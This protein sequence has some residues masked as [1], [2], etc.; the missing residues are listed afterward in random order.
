MNC[1]RCNSPAE[2]NEFGGGEFTLCCNICGFYSSRTIDTFVDNY[3]VFRNEEL[4]PLGVVVTDKGNIQ[5]F[6]ESQKQKHILEN[7][8]QGFTYFNKEWKYKLIKEKVEKS[9]EVLIYQ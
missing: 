6:S 1:P 3:P 8:T 5:Y 9:A 4:K 2:Y 7:K